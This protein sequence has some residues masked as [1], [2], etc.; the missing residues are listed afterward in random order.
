MKQII[1]HSID[2]H[3]S[4]SDLHNQNQAKGVIREIRRKWYYTIIRRPV[5]RKMWD[6]GVRWVSETTLLTH[7]S[8]GTLERLVPL[9][10][11]TREKS[12]ISEYLNFGFYEQI[13][14]KDNVG[15]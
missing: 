8:S 6:Y 13:W 15:V 4:E 9:T 11:E 7:S 1:T 14:F 3:I 10:E 5:L 2:Y 12:D